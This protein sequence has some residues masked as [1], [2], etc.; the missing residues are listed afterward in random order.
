VF[1]VLRGAGKL[2]A[3]RALRALHLS[4]DAE[5]AIFYWSLYMTH[6]ACSVA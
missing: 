4:Y 6:P 2:R 3:L 1:A 5:Q